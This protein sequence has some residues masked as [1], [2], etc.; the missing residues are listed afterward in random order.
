MKK[1]TILAI[2]LALVGATT[3]VKADFMTGSLSIDGNAAFDNS[4]IGSATEVTDWDGPE[5]TRTGNGAFSSI[6]RNTDINIVA[7]WS[8]N[9]GATPGFINFDGFTFNLGSSAITSQTPG[10]SGGVTVYGI[11]TLFGN[12]YSATTYAWTFSSTGTES[13]D[14]LEQSFQATLT[15]LPDGGTTVA[16]LGGALTVLGL[17]RRKL[18]A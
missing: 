11:G 16:L 12:G 7:P 2:T 5:T 14:P 18:A 4:V 17:V 3:A 6:P 1:T 8:F 9:S 13:G 15:V 10:P